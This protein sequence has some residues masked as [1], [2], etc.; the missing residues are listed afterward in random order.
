MGLVL[1]LA[2][3]GT[4]LAMRATPAGLALSALIG[5]AG[6]VLAGGGAAP[7]PE[8][9]RRLERE[10]AR[11]QAA[12]DAALARMVLRPHPELGAV[13]GDPEAWPLPEAVRRW[14]D[15]DG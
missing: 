12:T 15:G 8:A 9:E 14:R 2:A 4:L 7:D 3:Q 6:L 5:A 13:D 10:I 1:T 11:V